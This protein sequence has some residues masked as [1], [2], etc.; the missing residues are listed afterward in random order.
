VT[1][2]GT[3]NSS[4]PLQYEKEYAEDDD[5]FAEDFEGSEF[6]SESDFDDGASSATFA[7]AMRSQLLAGPSG[8]AEGLTRE[9]MEEIMDEF[10]DEFEIVGNKML[11]KVGGETPAENLDIMRKA[12]VGLD[13]EGSGP[14]QQ[15]EQAKKDADMI[16][17]RYLRVKQ[18][19]E[20]EEH[21]KMPVLHITGQDKKDR[22]D[23]ETILSE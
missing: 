18:E 17:K 23:A 22:W 5:E 10:L 9:D 1:W 7:R 19:G 21:E 3:R 15:S 2:A 16:R 20:D 12:L 6:M 14:T 13:L 4:F 8:E 11:P